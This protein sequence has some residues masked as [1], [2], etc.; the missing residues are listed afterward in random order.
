MF[1]T[2]LVC[3]F[4]IVLQQTVYTNCK[5]NPLNLNNLRQPVLI[6][7]EPT[8]SINLIKA[9]YLHWFMTKPAQFEQIRRWVDDK[10]EVGRFWEVGVEGGRQCDSAAGLWSSYFLCQIF[11]RYPTFSFHKKTVFT[12]F[13]EFVLNLFVRRNVIFLIAAY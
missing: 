13:S 9:T 2:S 11:S 6:T 3:V 10:K 5:A 4:I 12:V 8:L 7:A 1:H